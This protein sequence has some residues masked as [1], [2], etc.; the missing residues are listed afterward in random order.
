MTDDTAARLRATLARVAAAARRAGRDPAEIAL[1]GVAKQMPAEAIAQAVEAGLAHVG[2]SYV[3]EAKAKRPA[4]LA[5]LAARRVAPPRWHFVGR[6]Q[7]NKARAVA[8]EFD[9]L[10]SL[11]RPELCDALG[12]HA[13]AA[14]RTLEVLVQV[15]VAGEAQKGGAAPQAVGSL[16]RSCRRWP[17][18]RAVGLMTIPPAD[19]D[20]ERSRPVF[21]ALRALRDALRATPEGSGLRELSMGMTADFEVAIEEGATILRVGTA[22][23]GARRPAT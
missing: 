18:L 6:L 7:R 5:L 4:L 11:D 21:A 23:F 1:C 17:A 10:H 15:N 12:R 19:P 9:C 22:I 16:L 2:E 8:E 20:P 3:S 14:G 13:S